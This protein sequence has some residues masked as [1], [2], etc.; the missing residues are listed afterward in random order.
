MLGTH[1]I[2]YHTNDINNKEIYSFEPA[3]P[4]CMECELEEIVTYKL[5]KLPKFVLTALVAL[6]FTEYAQKSAYMCSVLDKMNLIPH[7]LS[8]SL[9][10]FRLY[11]QP[12]PKTLPE[13]CTL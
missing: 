1:K 3:S 11:S 13:K 12:I 6:R 8:K 9:T 10:S 5:E 4:Y 2:N 7:F